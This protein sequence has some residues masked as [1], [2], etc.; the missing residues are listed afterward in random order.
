MRKFILLFSLFVFT[1]NAGAQRWVDIGVKGGWGI[2]WLIN[3]NLSDDQDFN[4]Q[5][6]SGYT[7]GGKLG[8]NFND[9]HEITFDVMATTNRYKFKYN[10]FD[11]ISNSSPLYEKS[12]RFNVLEMALLYRNNKDGRYLEFG[13]SYSLV[14]NATGTNTLESHNDGVIRDNLINGYTSLIFGFGTYFLGTENF[15]ITLGARFSYTFNDLISEK[16]KVNHYPANNPYP[17]YKASHPF[18]ALLIAEAN[19][20]FAYMAKAKCKNKRKLILF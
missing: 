8:F 10:V 7:F 12:F 11:S 13:P 20:D 6:A 5:L 19:L 17:A 16:G 1:L 9:F 18:Y 2:N 4:N 3:K 15:G 14:R